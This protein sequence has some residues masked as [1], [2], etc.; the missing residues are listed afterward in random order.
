MIADL[1]KEGVEIYDLSEEEERNLLDSFQKIIPEIVG[2]VGEDG[3]ELYEI[4]K[5][6]Q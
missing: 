6:S 2:T 3:K 5:Q 4:I 1:K